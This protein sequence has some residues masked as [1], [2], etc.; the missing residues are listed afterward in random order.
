MSRGKSASSELCGWRTG[1]L[2][3]SL[4]P[5]GV[6]VLSTLLVFLESFLFVLAS[7]SGVAVRCKCVGTN[8]LLIAD[9]V[10][11][12]RNGIASAGSGAGTLLF[13]VTFA[14]GVFSLSSMCTMVLFFLQLFPSTA[15]FGS[16]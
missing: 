11:I 3:K 12:R 5:N 10:G 13:G 14:G 1:D 9:S 15:A 4:F 6:G 7:P 16:G 2:S 8:A